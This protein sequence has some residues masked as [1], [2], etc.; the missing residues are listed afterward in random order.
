MSNIIYK[1][2]VDIWMFIKYKIMTSDELYI[3]IIFIENS[4]YIE[5][6]S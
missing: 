5:N 6:Y 1:L 2:F 4:I 3:L